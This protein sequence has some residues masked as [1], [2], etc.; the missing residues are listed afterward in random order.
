MG[1]ADILISVKLD[2]A[3]VRQ[4]MQRARNLTPD[5]RLSFTRAISGRMVT[6]TVLRFHSQ[7]APD[8]VKWVPSKRAKKT[9][10]RTLHLKGYLEG[11]I[12]ARPTPDAAAWGSP[13][14]YAAAMNN[15]ASIQMYARS[16]QIYRRIVKD[17]LQPRFVKKSKSNFS[18]WATIGKGL[19]PGESYTINIPARPFLGL[20][21]DDR[22]EI[23]DAGASF[24]LRV[25]NGG[26]R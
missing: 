18:S 22:L 25:L 16:Q 3:E 23:Q 5:Q 9:G 4:A 7:T 19:K 11:S 10:G 8:G 20:S 6:S 21:D 13:L 12:V 2:D 15:G 26:A 1:A 24:V 17:R 14:R